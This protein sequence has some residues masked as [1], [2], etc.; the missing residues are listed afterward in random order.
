MIK[1]VGAVMALTK[2]VWDVG[3]R[4]LPVIEGM[5]K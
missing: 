1:D 3:E 2:T 4:L 5:F